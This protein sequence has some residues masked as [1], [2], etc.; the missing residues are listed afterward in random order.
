MYAG[1]EGWVLTNPFQ[2]NLE[3]GPDV[4]ND[5]VDFWNNWE[6]H[7][8]SSGAGTNDACMANGAN[9][10][11]PEQYVLDV[12]DAGECL[13]S[14]T[15]ASDTQDTGDD[16][17]CLEWTITGWNHTILGGFI[18]GTSLVISPA[19]AYRPFSASEVVNQQEVFTGHVQTDLHLL[20]LKVILVLEHSWFLYYYQ[21]WVETRLMMINL[22]LMMIMI[23]MVRQMIVML[24]M[25]M[26]APQM[27][28]IQMITMKMFV[29][30]QIVMDVM[31][32][33]PVAIM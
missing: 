13:T 24:M 5:A 27:V 16:S 14:W 26:M 21:P 6:C 15:Y 10:L 32:A 25:I 17:E 33:H 31:I 28:T 8:N 30:I 23:T 20:L 18:D 4:D 3:H 7:T 29:V 11:D 22:L 1:R 9:W 12:A 2:M 19:N